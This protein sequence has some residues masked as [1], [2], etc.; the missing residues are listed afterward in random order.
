MN[1][2]LYTIKQTILTEEFKLIDAEIVCESLNCKLLQDLAIKIYKGRKE[3]LDHLDKYYEEKKN[4]GYDWASKGTP[5]N[6]TFKQIFGNEDIVWNKITDADIEEYPATEDEKEQKKLDKKAREVI[7][8]NKKILIARNKDGEFTYFVNG[9]GTVYNLKK[10]STWSFHQGSN[11]SNYR[12]KDIPQYEKLE[13]LKGQT[14]YIID[15]SSSERNKIRQERYVAKSGTIMFDPD[16]LERI[17]KDNIE[18]YKKILR[19]NRANR[20]NNDELINKAKKIINRVASYAAMVAKDP[21]R[22]ADLISDVSNLSLWI[23]DK[24]HYNQPTRYNKQGYYT[25]VNGLLPMMMSYTKLVKDLSS[26]GG[27]E[28]QNN[29]LKSVQKEMEKAV[30]KA[31]ELMKK[32]EDKMNE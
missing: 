10:G 7:K 1:N 6:K 31:E 22:H 16:S 29:E 4:K 24:K 13:K 18:R 12:G 32:I 19:E 5:T 15:T 2:L 20:L 30:E 25:G 23:Y 14:L 8:G 21:V 17:A 26:G 9:W 3:E 27:Y 11:V 28:H